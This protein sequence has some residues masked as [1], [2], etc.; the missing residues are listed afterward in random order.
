MKKF[1]YVVIS[2]LLFFSLLVGCSTKEKEESLK[3]TAGKNDNKIHVVATLFPTY[4]FAKQILGDKGEVILLLPPGSESHSYEPTPD[5]IININKS[6]LFIYTGKYMESWADKI[7]QGITN[8]DVSVLDV[9]KGINLTKEEEH[10]EHEEHHH[11]YD[12][13]IWTSPVLAEKMVD[14]ILES[15]CK[16]DPNNASYYEENANKY[17]K[18]LTELNNEFKDIVQNGKRKEIVF[19]GRFAFNYFEKEYGLNHISAYDSCSTEGEPSAGTI[20][21]II[22]KIKNNKIP[23]IYYEELTDPKVAKSISDETGSK[24]LLMHSCHNIS[25]ND[26]K[27]GVTYLDIM[28]KNAVNLKEGL[29]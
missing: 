26:F 7:I 18:Q 6:N 4:D 21:K 16:I 11:E 25:K 10:E 28:K 22:T 2:I 3:E 5:D 27:K 17:K 20:S 12:P 14:N 8:K 29:N 19:G 13:H 15:I 9:S 1:F 24:M 23:V